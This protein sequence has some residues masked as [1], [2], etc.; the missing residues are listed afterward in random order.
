M[1]TFTLFLLC[2]TLTG[3]VNL[4]PKADT[5]RLFVLGSVDAVYESGSPGRGAFYIGRPDLPAYLEGTR[6]QYRHMDGEVESLS[7]A[8]WAEPLQEGVARALNEFIGSAQENSSDGYY[9]WPKLSSA[10]PQ[11]R[12]RLLQ[13]GAIADG[14]IQLNANW[15]I[16]GQGGVVAQGTFIAEG[17]KWQPSDP[18]SFVAGLNQALE[19]LAAEIAAAL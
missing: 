4:K 1:R 14:R 18:K 3:C 11:V 16:E 8:R 7:G 2:C 5:V 12:V 13:F 19:A 17:F 9:P 10:T 6:L 15:Q